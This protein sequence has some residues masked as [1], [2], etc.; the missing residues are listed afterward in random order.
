MIVAAE[1]IS[2][3]LS[4]IVPILLFGMSGLLTFLV[5]I[6]KQIS[7]MARFQAETV[8]VLKVLSDGSAENRRKIEDVERFVR[9]SN[10]RRDPSRT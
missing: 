9:D 1:N 8:I 5:W 6:V 3:P 10:I 2:I 7:V 4:V